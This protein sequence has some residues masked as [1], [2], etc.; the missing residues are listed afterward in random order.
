MAEKISKIKNDDSSSAATTET[1]VTAAMT[2]STIWR[3]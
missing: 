2:I 3:E 1:Q